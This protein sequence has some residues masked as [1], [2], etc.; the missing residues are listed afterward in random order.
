MALNSLQLLDDCDIVAAH[1]FLFS[2]RPDTPAERMPQLGAELVKARA[3]RLRRQADQRRSAW[4]DSL[5]GSM[6]PVLV[7]NGGKAHTDAFAPVLMPAAK[8][9]E[10][11]K[12]RITGRDGAFLAGS[13]E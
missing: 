6:Q 3:S 7:E 8:A 9:G 10:S 5:V 12:A 13:F 4:L 11:G 1:V 2:P